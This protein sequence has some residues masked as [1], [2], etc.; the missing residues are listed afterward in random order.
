MGQQRRQRSRPSVSPGSLSKEMG[1]GWS[2][3]AESGPMLI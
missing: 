2:L 1:T 3:R